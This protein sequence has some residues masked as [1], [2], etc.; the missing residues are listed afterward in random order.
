M[1]GNKEMVVKFEVEKTGS[2][3]NELVEQW[4]TWW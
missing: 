1:G 2:G 3:I 4:N